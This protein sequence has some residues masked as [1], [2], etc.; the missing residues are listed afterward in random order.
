LVLFFYFRERRKKNKFWVAI[1]FTSSKSF[2]EVPGIYSVSTRF[3]FAFDDDERVGPAP[4]THARH[5]IP[6]LAA[7]LSWKIYIFYDYVYLKNFPGF[8]SLSLVTCC[9]QRIFQ[10]RGPDGEV[11]MMCT[12]SIYSSFFSFDSNQ[13]L[14]LRFGEMKKKKEPGGADEMMLFG[15]EK[16]ACGAF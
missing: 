9:T 4:T 11:M 16:S 1:L 2:L 7:Y 10:R 3:S 15:M 5:S 8:L 14:S 6:V 13:S 12:Y